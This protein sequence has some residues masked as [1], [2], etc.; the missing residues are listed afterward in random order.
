MWR[1]FVWIMLALSCGACA[2]SYQK[3]GV[4][5]PVPWAKAVTLQEFQSNIDRRAADKVR[6][7]AE[8]RSIERFWVDKKTPASPRFTLGVI[9]LNDEGALNPAQHD[10]VL[11]ALRC[12]LALA[13]F[14]EG[15]SAKA[16]DHALKTQCLS[17]DPSYNEQPGSK[18]TLLMIF[19]HGWHH[20]CRTCDRD[21][22]CFRTVL[23]SLSLKEAQRG[24][25][26]FGL[27]VG[28][29][30]RVF[31]N[32]ALNY[33]SIWDRKATAEHLGRTG[34]KELLNELHALWDAN[35]S[36]TMVTVGHSL[37][38]ALLL[39]AARGHLTG[40]V[41]D[42]LRG[43]ERSYRIARSKT[44]H[45]DALDSKPLRSRFGDL[46]VLLN[47]AVEAAEWEPFDRDLYDNG[48][49]DELAQLTA[50]EKREKLIKMRMPIDKADR[51]DSKQLPV[52]I[53]I[54][55]SA[56]VAVGFYFPFSRVLGVVNPKRWLTIH[57]GREYQAVGRY[58]P[59]VT[60]RLSVEPV[61][62]PAAPAYQMTGCKCPDAD[63]YYRK[64]KAAEEEREAAEKSKD[65]AVST[66]PDDVLRKDPRAMFNRVTES[67]Q[68]GKKTDHQSAAADQPGS[69]LIGNIPLVRT[70]NCRPGEWKKGCTRGWDKNSP[71]IVIKTDGSAISG[72]SDVF[73]PAVAGMLSEYLDRF[74][75]Y[76]LEHPNMREEGF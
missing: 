6:I 9:E 47:P 26:V 40:S 45:N 48:V 4:E 30:G 34:G 37:G 25:R 58:A 61:S 27:Y 71:Y 73:N 35:K 51:Y 53:S 38:G 28:W 59:Y 22:T 66:P 8:A 29:R 16:M 43:E 36:T 75:A 17:L 5:S 11:Q 49:A 65:A 72:H 19:V 41:A 24:R 14:T 7:D 31:V 18:G 32:Q 62:G 13:S 2:T 69:S 57:R 76:R 46:V 15:G 74:E 23:E 56:D 55:S 67:G 33:A 39:Q 42:V 21:L 60:H 1:R 63:A 10:Q 54:S 50:A 44:L 68:E 64:R 52:M 3:R 12:E 20:G 70:R